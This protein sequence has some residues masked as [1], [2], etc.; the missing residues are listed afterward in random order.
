MV[1]NYA[2]KILLVDDN[3]LFLKMMGRSF[4]NH[5][6]DCSFATSGD[7]AITFL[8]NNPPPDIILSD[9]EM[10]GMNGIEF[11]Q[12]LLTDAAFKDIPF[13][14]L[15]NLSDNNLMIT[16]LDLRAIDYVVKDTPVKVI[17]SKINNILLT[18]EKQR[19]LS[20]L[21]IKKAAS[22]L[23]FKSIPVKAP[24]IKLFKVEF[25]HRAYHDIPGGD[26][27]DFI[28]VN[29]RYS[30]VVLGDIMGKK[31]M[32]WFFTFGFLSYIRSAIRFAVFGG[33]YSVAQILQKVNGVIC[34]DNMLKDILSSL[35]LLLVDSETGSITYAGAGDLPLLHYKAADNTIDKVAS[36]GLLLGLFENGNYN[37]QKINLEKGDKLFIFT[38]GMIDF[39]ADQNKKSD[40]N[41]FTDTLKP[42]LINNISF[43]ELKEKIFVQGADKQVDDQS[44]ISLYKN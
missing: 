35:S 27:I 9:Y 6:F 26:F 16:G 30:F 44:I 10:P 25:W 23:N 19:E 2:K 24:L 43:T 7:D 38:D 31:W 32:A 41:L 37:E 20:E 36:S 42:Y 3:E 14:F 18:I 4:Q 29:D 5:G 1:N 17:L 40:Y 21:E 39:A 11:R 22:S 15:T 12:Y 8:Q 28:Q 33:D 13:V 34:F